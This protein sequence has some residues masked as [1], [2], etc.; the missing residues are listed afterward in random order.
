MKNM[1][2]VVVVLVVEQVLKCC[3]FKDWKGC[4]N[5]Y[6]EFIAGLNHFGQD[7][8]ELR[9]RLIYHLCLVF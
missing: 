8:L 4:K 9:I 2:V 6:P 5:F 3:E 7:G 1:D